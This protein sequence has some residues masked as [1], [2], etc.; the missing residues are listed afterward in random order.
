MW[1]G[2]PAPAIVTRSRSSTGIVVAGTNPSTITCVQPRHQPGEQPADPADV[3]EREHERVAVVGGEL[4][5]VDHRVRRRAAT[6]L[7]V[8]RAPFG[9]AVVPDV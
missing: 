5:H 7:S 2:V 4:E 8:C 3:R 6:V 1:N 9:S